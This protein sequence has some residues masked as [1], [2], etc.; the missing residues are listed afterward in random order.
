MK[1]A[2][3]GKPFTDMWY[4]YVIK[5]LNSRYKYVGS[6]NDLKR[7][8]LEHNNG[9]CESSRPYKPFELV[10]YVAV[11][12]KSKAIELEKYFKSGSGIAFLNSRIL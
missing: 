7:R 11:K 1:R 10:A 4:I 5:S 3:D 2:S 12:N 6:T 8:I 9:V